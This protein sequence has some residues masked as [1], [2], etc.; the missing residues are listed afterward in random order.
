MML[1]YLHIL[2]LPFR[3]RSF[4]LLLFSSLPLRD[5]FRLL[6][7]SSADAH[8]IDVSPFSSPFSRYFIISMMPSFSLIDFRHISVSPFHSTLI[9]LFL[10]LPLH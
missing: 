2:L 7:F 9:S 8:D 4:Y 5:Y 3:L 6:S 1:I 10:S